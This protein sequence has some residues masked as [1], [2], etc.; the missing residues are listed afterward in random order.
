MWRSRVR[1]PHLARRRR[2]QHLLEWLAWNGHNVTNIGGMKRTVPIACSA[3]DSDRIL[4]SRMR[5][6]LIFLCTFIALVL[7]GAGVWNLV[8]RQGS[9]G[10]AIACF[11]VSFVLLTLLVKRYL[12][13]FVAHGRLPSGVSLGDV[14]AA[15]EQGRRERA[16]ALRSAQAWIREHERA[17]PPD[18][19]PRPSR[20][21]KAQHR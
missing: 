2:H 14:M 20:P 3:A 18:A 15:R 13:P 4:R 7:A 21:H 1:F 8:S 9:G 16:A 6:D 12:I 19:Q 5:S 17:L 11:I 10:A